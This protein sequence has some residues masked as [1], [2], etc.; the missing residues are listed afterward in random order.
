MKSTAIV[1]AVLAGTFGLSSVA[2]AQQWGDRGERGQHR[3]EQRHERNEARH[4]DRRDHRGDRQEWNR[5]YR[6]PQYGYSQPHYQYRQPH[7]GYAQPGYRSAHRF[8]RGSYLPHEYRQRG[9]YVS[10]WQ[11]YPGLYAPAYGQQWVN[12]DGQFLLVALASGLVANA[13]LY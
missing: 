1:F 11:A 4:D 8:Y 3:A 10:N 13:L 12:V 7:Y 2:S 9:Y 6:Q 5:G